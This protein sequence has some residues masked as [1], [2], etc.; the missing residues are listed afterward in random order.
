LYGT[1]EIEE[2]AQVS[3]NPAGGGV[4]NIENLEIDGKKNSTVRIVFSSCTD[5]RI[6]NKVKIDGYTEINT[7]GPRVTFYLGDMNSDDEKFKVSEGNVKINANIYIKKG[8]LK[9]D[10]ESSAP[11]VLRG[12]FIAERV[13]TSGKN[14]TWNRNACSP[15]TGSMENKETEKLV[16]TGELTLQVMAT[17]NPSSQYFTLKIE[18]NSKVPVTLRLTDLAGRVITTK[19]GL[20]ANGTQRVG[21]D[22]KGGAYFVEV[23]QGE[24]RRVIKLIKL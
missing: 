17:P 14:I 16:E 24:L 19:Q 6:K 4:V 5:L 23:I 20:P 22:L 10:G 13:I 1:I 12:W 21:E 18:S 11:T 7:N 9:V 15:P 2:G 3:F 8:K